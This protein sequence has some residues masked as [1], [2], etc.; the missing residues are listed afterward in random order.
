MAHFRATTE[1]I[2]TQAIADGTAIEG[3]WSGD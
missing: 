2:R 1:R 3:D